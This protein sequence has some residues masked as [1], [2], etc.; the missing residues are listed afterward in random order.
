[1]ILVVLIGQIQILPFGVVITSKRLNSDEAYNVEVRDSSMEHQE[2]CFDG[3]PPHAPTSHPGC[4]DKHVTLCW[5]V[6]WSHIDNIK[7]RNLKELLK[8]S[9]TKN[10]KYDRPS[11]GIQAMP[12][13]EENNQHDLVGFVI[14]ERLEVMAEQQY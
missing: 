7:N 6:F 13:L 14:Y 12:I 8:A 1:M 5:R 3:P 9:D 4:T 11:T 10:Q 2:P